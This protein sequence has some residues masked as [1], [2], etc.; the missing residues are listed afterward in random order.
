M[1]FLPSGTS[2]QNMSPRTS[3]NLPFYDVNKNNTM[4]LI[5]MRAAGGKRFPLLMSSR[6]KVNKTGFSFKLYKLRLDNL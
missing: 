5:L 6:R 3:M 1:T 4:F 2:R